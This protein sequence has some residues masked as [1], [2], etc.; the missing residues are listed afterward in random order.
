MI[1]FTKRP[2]AA[3]QRLD[4]LQ[5]R[6]PGCEAAAGDFPGNPVSRVLAPGATKTATVGDSAGWPPYPHLLPPCGRLVPS[7]RM[8][9]FP[10]GRCPCG[11]PAANRQN[12]RTTRRIRNTGRVR[13]YRQTVRTGCAGGGQG[14]VRGASRSWSVTKATRSLSRRLAGR[15]PPPRV[16]LN[17]PLSD[18]VRQCHLCL[19]RQLGRGCGVLGSPRTGS[20][21]RAAGRS[22]ALWPRW[23]TGGTAPARSGP[24]ALRHAVSLSQAK[25]RPPCPARSSSAFP[26]TGILSPAT[27]RLGCPHSLD[28]R[29]AATT[30]PYPAAS[31]CWT[32][33][34]PAPQRKYRFSLFRATLQFG[35]SRDTGAMGH[36]QGFD[37]SQ[38][39]ELE[40]AAGL[41]REAVPEDP[42][43]RESFLPTDRRLQDSFSPASDLRGFPTA[44]WSSS[45]PMT[46]ATQE[47]QKRTG[48]GCRLRV[49]TLDY[50][51]NI[52]QRILN[53]MIVDNIS[54]EKM[55]PKHNTIKTV[56][57]R[58]HL[59][60]RSTTRSTGRAASASLH[61][62]LHR[63]GQLQKIQ[64]HPR[65][66]GGKRCGDL[67]P[68]LEGA[69]PLHRLAGRTA[70][71][72]SASSFPRPTAATR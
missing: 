20:P 3:S 62:A 32:A 10:R 49:A 54:Y 17:R 61:A 40:M 2:P 42:A 25:A 4:W 55:P 18:R 27:P 30:V 5:G 1:T 33:C 21:V 56:S 65:P 26:R 45:G 69:A 70:A 23:T 35:S 7:P 36:P 57:D 43:L 31:R 13:L 53:L 38:Q 50:L 48:P 24:R 63:P 64:R 52:E 71:T 72:S 34:I 60:T 12:G 6:G 66:S 28:P 29:P 37:F 41:E 15:D 22:A 68:C 39:E 9:P 46:A 11:L 16:L 14:H 8:R 59:N 44:R 58:P 67:R 19:Q 47:P 51:F